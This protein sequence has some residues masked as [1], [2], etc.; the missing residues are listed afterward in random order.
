MQID[1]QTVERIL[2]TVREHSWR[3]TPNIK[4]DLRL[5]VNSLAQQGVLREASA[6]DLLAALQQEKN[7]GVRA[8]LA[9]TDEVAVAFAIYMALK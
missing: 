9:A 8:T 7:T 3:S 6:E 4:A 5:A 2:Q 1:L